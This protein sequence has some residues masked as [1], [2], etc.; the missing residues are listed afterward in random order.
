MIPVKVCGITNSND[1]L[2]CIHYGVPALGFIFAESKRRVT[3]EVARKISLHLP[4]F[5]TKVGVFVDEDPDTIAEIL[6]DCRLDV[7]Q[8]HG[9]KSVAL[10]DKL[11]GR[12][13]KVFRA[14]MDQ[15]DPSWSEAPLRA[16]L[17]DTYQPGAQGGT[18]VP[19]NWD[20]F[21]EY[22]KL[23][24]PL[25]LA[26]GLNPGN[27]LSAIQTARPDAVD[28]SSG[29]EI[30]PGIKDLAKVRELMSIVQKIE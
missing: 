13:I 6:R 30:K 18:G 20:L 16:V 26:G 11:P 5:V 27:I 28:L 12:V 29:V 17:I 7:A 8:L 21:G 25:I 2:T 4:P 1:A 9:S 24:F 22:R 23:G 15:P 19:F 14:G 10:I 3:P